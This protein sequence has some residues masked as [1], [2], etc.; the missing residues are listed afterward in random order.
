M[1]VCFWE[2]RMN[3]HRAI[4]NYVQIKMEGLE[5]MKKE[6][7]YSL[8]IIIPIHHKRTLESMIVFID[9]TQFLL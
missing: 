9:I 4:D 1:A 3:E 5:I 8:T 2:L 6:W 7:M